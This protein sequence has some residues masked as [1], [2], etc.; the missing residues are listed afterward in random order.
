MRQQKAETVGRVSN[1]ALYFMVEV[2][3]GSERDE[4]GGVMGDGEGGDKRASSP[5]VNNSSLNP[6]PYSYSPLL[7]LQQVDVAIF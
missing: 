6:R 2:W 4:W 7:W 5:D 3:Y 1:L